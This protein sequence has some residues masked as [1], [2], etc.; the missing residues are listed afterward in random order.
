MVPSA[1][2]SVGPSIS[3]AVFLFFNCPFTFALCREE[4]RRWVILRF[5][6]NALQQE[7]RCGVRTAS[8]VTVLLIYISLVDQWNCSH[9]RFSR[10]SSSLLADS[11]SREIRGGLVMS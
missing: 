5:Y 4:R 1:T 11:L 10:S 9:L 7:L 3:W 8:R 2:V 6:L